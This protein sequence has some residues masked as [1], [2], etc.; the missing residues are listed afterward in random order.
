MYEKINGSPNKAERE[1]WHL[2][3][4]DYMYYWQLYNGLSQVPRGV[5][6][7]PDAIESWNSRSTGSGFWHRPEFIVPK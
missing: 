2:E 1:E 5:A 4:V 3:M 6:Y 7:D